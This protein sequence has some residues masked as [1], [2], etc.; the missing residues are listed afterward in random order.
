M[1]DRRRLLLWDVDGTLVSAGPA[2]RDA[3]DLAV[4]AVIGRT[5]AEHGVHMS[6]KTDPQIAM[7]ILAAL[8]IPESE[9]RTYLPAVLEGLEL[10]LGEAVEA[11]RRDGRVLPGV[12]EVLERL[13]AAPGIIQT[14]LTGNLAAN[15]SLKVGAFGLDRWLDLEVGAFGSDDHDRTK[16]VPI[17]VGKIEA[18]DG[19]SFPPQEIWVIGDTPRDLDCARTAGCN[20]LLVATGRYGHQELE[21]LGADALLPDLSDTVRV[22][23]ILAGEDAVARSE[24]MG[25]R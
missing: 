19:Y 14:V 10:H 21:G 9:A 11:I 15:A 25:W 6:G 5:A 4:E 20:C 16:L 8:A 7:E 18:R 22:A 1:L 24:G 13:H 12:S 2:A 3:F 17:A 23:A